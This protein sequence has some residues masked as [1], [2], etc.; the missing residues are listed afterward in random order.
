MIL[1]IMRHGV[2]VKNED[3]E[4]KEEE[5]FDPELTDKG[6]KKANEIACGLEHI[7]DE[8]ELPQLIISSPAKRCYE[9]AEIIHEHWESKPPI[10]AVNLFAEKSN[11]MRM[12]SFIDQL[13]DIPVMLVMHKPDIHQLIGLLIGAGENPCIDFKR[14]SVAKIEYAA[15]R[16][17]HEWEL[18]W[19]YDPWIIRQFS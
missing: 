14:G 9:T 12:K 17:E 2:A 6:R 15:D 7:I 13:P 1:Y 16:G 11:V 5:D 3:R 4:G 18:C 19:L 8:S 10:K